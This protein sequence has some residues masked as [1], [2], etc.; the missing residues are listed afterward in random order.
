MNGEPHPT[1][2]FP[3]DTIQSIWHS[4][5]PSMLHALGGAPNTDE[6]W[7][8]PDEDVLQTP[9][10]LEAWMRKIFAYDVEIESAF[11]PD[12]ALAITACPGVPMTY[13]MHDRGLTLPAL[14]EDGASLPQ[15]MSNAALRAALEQQL[16]G[17][18]AWVVT[19]HQMDALRVAVSLATVKV[20]QQWRQA[21]A[22]FRV[23]ENEY[24][25]AVKAAYPSE[26][27]ALPDGF[28]L[29]A[30]SAA[31][32]NLKGGQAYLNLEDGAGY[33]TPEGYTIRLPYPPPELQFPIP[34]QM[35]AHAAA[36]S[37]LKHGEAHTAASFN[38]CSYVLPARYDYDV[39]S[40]CNKTAAGASGE[41]W[42]RP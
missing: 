36:T 4:I 7:I 30:L 3:I 11:R 25:A 22:G 17:E 41:K 19:G 23:D 21:G 35:V 42:I 32:M 2:T 6:N 33:F 37:H 31:A 10:K 28:L 1:W 18:V 39:R 38:G 12:E 20:W 34:H 26:Y 9:G 15:G 24:V 27:E 8:A 16:G 14:P 13:L 40:T 5:Y 29:R